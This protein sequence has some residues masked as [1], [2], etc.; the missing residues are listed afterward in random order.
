VTTSTLHANNLILFAY[1]VDAGSF[2]L[3]AERTGY[4]KATLS[5]YMT[6]L[7][8]ALGERLLQR[9]TRRLALTEFG[10]RMLE[11][12]RRMSEENDEAVALAGNRQAE[13]RGTLRISLPP[14][15]GPLPVADAIERFA[16]RYPQVRL[17]LD[18]SARRVDLIAE[19]FDIAIRAAAQLPDDNTLVARRLTTQQSG[20]Y[21]SP[22]YLQENGIPETPDALAEHTGLILAVRG[23]PQPWPGQSHINYPFIRWF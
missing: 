5:R 23:E 21:A 11:H 22:D 9:S 4:S 17:Q 15:F 2:T 6:R 8:E 12:A 13:P 20:L 18:L 1:I 10:E 3:A 16:R 19:R 14:E 7:E